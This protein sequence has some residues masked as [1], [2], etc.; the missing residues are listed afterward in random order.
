[1][2]RGLSVNVTLASALVFGCS[3][4][5]ARPA[6][7]QQGAIQ[8]T[9]SD[10]VTGEP[11]ATA[12]VL[13]VGT[14][15]GEFTD[16][17]GSFRIDLPSGTY[18]VRVSFIGYETLSRRVTV[19]A[20]ETATVDFE[21]PIGGLTVDPLVVIGS[22]TARTE[23]NSPV[24]IDVIS[25]A[26][27]RESPHVEVNQI[28]R[29]LVPSYNA[30]HQTI[31][32]GTDHINPASLRGLGPDQTLVLINGKRRHT[33]SVVHVNGTFGRGTVGVD[34]NSIPPAAIQR[35]EVLRDGAA[36]QYGSDAIAGVINIVLKDQTESL[37]ATIMGG[38]TGEGDG[39][40][41]FVDA[42]FGFPIGDRGFFNIT[43]EFLNRERTDRSEPEERDLFP[44]ISGTEATD[45]ELAARGLTREDFSM[46]TGQAKA[47]FG[48]GFFNMVV[49]ISENAEVYSFGGITHRKGR[50][51]G[52]YRRPIEEGRTVL[53]I[54]PNGYLPEI[55][56]DIGDA[57]IAAGVRG[58]RGGWD[59]DG[60]LAFGTNSLRWNI[61]NTLNSSQGEASSTT[62]DAGRYVFSETVGNVDAVKLIDT[63]GALESLSLVLGA[64]FRVE[65]F[66]EEAGEASSFLLGNGGDIPGV[67]FDTTSAGDPKDAGSQVFF[68]RTPENEVD[69]FR[70]SFAG[71]VGLE[72]QIT[73]K[74]LLDLSGRFET[75]S[76]F[77]STFNGK[78]ATRYEIVPD[79][80]L[81]GA[82]STGFR[83]PSLH[84]IWFSDVSIQFV[85]DPETNE[86]AA[87]RVLTARNQDPVTKAFGIPDLKEETSI[88]VSGG[89][90]WRPIQD[91]SITT[92]VYFI[93]IDDR[94]VLTSRFSTSDSEIG[95]IVEDILEPFER[96]GVSQAQFFS[97]IVDTE[98]FG[99]DIVATYAAQLGG[100][101]L[102]L[103]GAASF[104]DTDVTAV[105]IPPEVADV[106]TGGDLDAVRDVLFSREERNRLE[107][108]LPRQKGLLQA[109]YGYNR[110]SVTGRANY[111]GNVQYK[112]SNPD[113]DED[114]SAKTLFDLDLGYEIVRG[115][116]LSVGANN[117]FN[118]FPDEHEK[119]SNRSG[120]RFPFSRR[121][122][123]FGMNGGFYYGRIQM[124]L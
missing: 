75:F 93:A 91:L 59:L 42:N 33:S 122:T 29:E 83:A 99:I 90:V 72:S 89:F 1:M 10:G 115:V 15:R 77:G 48:A 13:V 117:M 51:T 28:I 102:S 20:G 114:F 97:N 118:T 112:P 39:A 120:G 21:L 65:R 53:E 25:E 105:N 111:Y 109:S 45:A 46:K 8:G 35:I 52:F 30:S 14:A 5:I 56:P 121:V 69:R 34:L 92:D 108:A 26:E 87:A 44:G 58:S 96:A 66:Q 101:V 63:K 113:N 31:G 64:E 103:T 17:E 37:Q 100:G 95:D 11:L 12:T 40:E 79:F 78:L 71:Y 94:I 85:T 55:N 116:R 50:A 7:A 22:R 80:A 67:D 124:N 73:D 82:L 36:A 3:L 19:V 23:F 119:A 4:A 123:Q 32:D 106:F 88:N 86:L 27:I 104:T 9:V 70:N 38:V 81:R 98:T 24:P 76:D 110:F 6:I 16:D 62:F 61:E 107:D 68:G 41:G 57:S 74:W 47:Q 84:Q 18:T 54:F 49:P 43:A 60:S 2:S